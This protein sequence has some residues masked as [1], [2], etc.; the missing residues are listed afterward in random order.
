MQ[1]VSIC[2]KCQHLFSG[3]SRE[4]IINL[5]SGEF[6]QRVVKIEMLIDRLKESVS[7]S[8]FLKDHKDGKLKKDKKKSKLL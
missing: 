5:E 2:M 1:I 3:K 6:S 7:I 8:G 4:Y